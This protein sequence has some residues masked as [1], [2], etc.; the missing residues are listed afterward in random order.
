MFA[1]SDGA[2][3]RPTIIHVARVAGVSR[4]TV[5]RVLNNSGAVEPETRSRVEAAIAMLQYEPD[6][7]ARALGR[8]SRARSSWNPGRSAEKPRE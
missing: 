4:S 5:S 3:N 2:A 6:P 1:K 8:Q 7:A